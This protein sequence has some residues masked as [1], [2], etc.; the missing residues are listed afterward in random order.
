MSGEVTRSAMGASQV[1]DIIANASPLETFR[2]E[3]KMKDTMSYIELTSST[4]FACATISPTTMIMNVKR[5]TVSK[6][7]ARAMLHTFN[8][9]SVCLA[10][11]GMHACNQAV[12]AVAI[13]SL[14]SPCFFNV[15]KEHVDPATPAQIKL[16]IWRPGHVSV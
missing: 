4:E 2:V 6:A 9:Q 12:K 8:T 16:V 5:T 7:L 3:F 1:Y 11:M 14:K 15:V 10:T 13:A